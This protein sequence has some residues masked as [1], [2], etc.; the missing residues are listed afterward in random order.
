MNLNEG[1]RY[2]DL[3]YLRSVSK[4]NVSFEQKML[5]TFI[6]QADS[7]VQ[8]LRQAVVVMDWDTIHLIAHKMKPSLQFVGLECLKA[9]MHT[10]ETIAKQHSDFD[11]VTSLISHIFTVIGIAIEEIKDD[12]ISFDK[13]Q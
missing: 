11:R 13:N 1:K 3:S 5:Q 8:K 2:T 4:G 9:D 10:L 12:L 7:D 6:H